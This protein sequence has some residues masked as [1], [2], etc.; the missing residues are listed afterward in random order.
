MVKMGRPVMK[1]KDRSSRLVAL[2]LTPAEYKTLEQA[3][4]R[5][6]LTISNYLRF[7][8]GLRSDK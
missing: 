1:A 3:A 5:S 8:L 4:G 2:R 6:K 7:K